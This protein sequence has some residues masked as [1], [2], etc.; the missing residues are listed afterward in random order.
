MF[1][2]PLTRAGFVIALGSSALLLTAI[3]FEHLGGLSPCELCE[4]Q[5]W[6]HAG[7]IVYGVLVMFLGH[8]RLGGIAY[9]AALICL[10]MTAA[11]GFYHVGVEQGWWASACST[12]APTHGSFADIKAQL[13]AAPIVKCDEIAWSLLGLSMAAW[14]ILASAGVAVVSAAVLITAPKPPQAQEA[15]A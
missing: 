15:P 13:E 10:G 7:A 3:G 14:N 5:R 6:W 4:E 1:F 11:F 8:H 2:D 12:G 9:G